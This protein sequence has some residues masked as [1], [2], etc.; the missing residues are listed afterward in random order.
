M[1][2]LQG[3]GLAWY[4]KCKIDIAIP[5]ERSPSKEHAKNTLIKRAK[6]GKTKHAK[7]IKGANKH[8]IKQKEG[9]L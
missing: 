1:P 6:R 9:V 5:K 4:R 7:H 8:V 3:Y 2:T